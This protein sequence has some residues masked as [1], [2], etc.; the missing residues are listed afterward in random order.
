MSLRA[1]RGVAELHGRRDASDKTQAGPL[2]SGAT[3]DK[4]RNVVDESGS[5]RPKRSESLKTNRVKRFLSI[6]ST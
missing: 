3:L 4:R 6:F 5:R 2:L 1:A